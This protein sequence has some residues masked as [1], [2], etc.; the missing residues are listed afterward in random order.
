MSSRFL[1]SRLLLWLLCAGALVFA[2]GPLLRRGQSTAIAAE[3]SSARAQTAAPSP[4]RLVASANVTVR[5]GVVLSL[6]V[7]NAEDHA[8]EIEFP[9][10][11]T[12]EFV[13]LDS[14][15]R[16]VWR[17]STGRLFTQSMR[18]KLLDANESLTY[19]ERWEGKARPGT[20]TAVA[21]LRSS[22]FPIEER[23]PFT[24]P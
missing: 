11:Q 2:C 7:T 24:L 8:V 5:R 12:H 17:W 22:N 9:D 1:G 15:G 23:V 10:G 20:Y 4:R 14:V 21:T 16:E 18:N 13:V 6:H 3:A 19:Q